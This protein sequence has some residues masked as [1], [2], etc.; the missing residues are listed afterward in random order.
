MHLYTKR[1]MNSIRERWCSCDSTLAKITARTVAQAQ[2]SENKQ[3]GIETSIQK[4]RANSL[5]HWIEDASTDHPAWPNG[6]TGHAARSDDLLGLEA[7]R[8]VSPGQA[9]RSVDAAATPGDDPVSWDA[10]GRQSCVVTH[11]PDRPALWMTRFH[12]SSTR[13]FPEGPRTAVT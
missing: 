6:S 8:G 3:R 5:H 13:A 2:T 9:G 10:H 7:I 12:W 1:W 4:F 11:V